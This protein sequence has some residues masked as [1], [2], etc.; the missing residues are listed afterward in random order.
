MTQ[1]MELRAFHGVTR[2]V[3][4]P[5]RF[6]LKLAIG[7]D[8]YASLR[9]KKNLSDLWEVSGAA[10][11]GAGVAASPVVATT[12]FASTATAGLLS[13]VGLGA[14]ATTP[15]GWVVAAAV[16]SGGA[17]FGVVKLARKY[18]GSRVETIP[19]FINTPLDLLGA[20]L[21]DLIAGLATRLASI[22]GEVVEAEKQTIAKHFIE[23]WGLSA[24]YVVRALDVLIANGSEQRVKQL[25][26]AVA[27][28]VEQNPDCNAAVLREQIIVFLRDV[29][30]ADGVLDEREELAIDAIANVFSTEE[31]SALGKV[32]DHLSS[33]FTSTTGLVRS[34]LGLAA[35]D[36]SLQRT[37]S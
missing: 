10:A 29:A 8:A 19:K 11:T 16:A 14:A 6:K 9:L 7:E 15:I 21:L 24:D 28:F 18:S 13:W 32:R 31:G 20:S 36:P 35:G 4:D 17:Y 2:V 23:E 3:A 37:E 22:D 12:L 1:A 5:L 33:A 27:R 26:Q 30:G 34:K 25:A